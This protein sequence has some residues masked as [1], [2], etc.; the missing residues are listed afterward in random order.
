MSFI[1]VLYLFSW[2]YVAVV[3]DVCFVQCAV[4]CLFVCLFV[5]QN[6]SYNSCLFVSVFGF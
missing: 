6:V 2:S 4:I 3:R 5:C 1:N